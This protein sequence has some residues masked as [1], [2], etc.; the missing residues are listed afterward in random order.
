MYTATLVSCKE[1]M[2]Q[3]LRLQEMNLSMNIDKAEMASQGF[4]TLHHSLDILSQMH[5]LAPSVIIKEGKNVVG[6]ALT[7]L[8]ECRLLMS[9]LE[10]MFAILDSLTWNNIPLNDYR[11]YVMGQICIAKEYRGKGL[12]ELLYQQ[13]R[14]IYKSRFDL[15][16]TE[17]SARN[18]RSIRAHEKAG[19]R[20]IHTH[21]DNLDN[22]F[23]VGWDWK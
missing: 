17:I 14:K 23:V 13:H 2:Q 11:F 15:V 4:V 21:R 9:D 10:P 8:K 6:Y 18:H 16:I 1:E 20:T 3:I 7:M 22:W 5:D 19:F 12:V